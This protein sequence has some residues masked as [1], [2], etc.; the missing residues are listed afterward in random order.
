MHAN[1]PSLIIGSGGKGEEGVYTVFGLVGLVGAY[2]RLNSVS[3]PGSFKSDRAV[4]GLARPLYYRL[5]FWQSG[6]KT[7]I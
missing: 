3:V 4:V 7:E 6:D 1:I 2:K 5:P